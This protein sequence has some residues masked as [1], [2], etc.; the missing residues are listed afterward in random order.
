MNKIMK[1]CSMAILMLGIFI[2]A[3]CSSSSGI[4]GELSV[5]AKRNELVVT[6]DFEK[7]SKLENGTATV[8]VK[9]Y[10]EDESYNTSNTVTLENG[11]QGTTTFEKL[12][13]D[14]KYILKLFVSIS[15]HEEEIYKLETATKNDGQDEESAITI[16]TVEEFKNI[17]DDPTAYYKLGADLDF[18]DEGSIGLFSSSSTAFSGTFDGNGYSIKNATLTSNQ[19]TGLFG[20][21]SNA[22]IK[23]LTITDLT[24]ELKSNLGNSIVAIGGVAGYAENCIFENVKAENFTMKNT[25]TSNPFTSSSAKVYFGGFAGILKTS[26][27]KSSSI[28]N[29]SIDNSNITLSYI[30]GGSSTT[31]P[32]YVYVGLFAGQII[33]STIVESSSAKGNLDISLNL[34]TKVNAAIGGFTGALSSE[35]ILKS[36]YSDCTIKATKSGS[37]VN[38]TVA[39]G[40]LIGKNPNDGKCNVDDCLAIADITILGA[41]DEEKANTI[42]FAEKFYVGG[43]I[44]D[45]GYRSTEGVK[46]SVYSPKENGIK[47]LSQ[48]I[49]KE[50]DST[51]TYNAKIS[52]TFGNV[53]TAYDS[54]ILSKIENV[55]ALDDVKTIDI[56]AKLTTTVDGE[57]QT[58]DVEDTTSILNAIIDTTNVS[59][60]GIDYLSETLKSLL[61]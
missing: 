32:S 51:T 47:V 58:N 55:Y 19:Y 24:F 35:K 39:V 40:G 26:T 2:L 31:N 25:G 8:S 13:V 12:T 43:L 9:L 49:A 38:G 27:S 54:D 30:S 45:L 42:K 23:N 34:Y 60:S 4:K 18:K 17:K 29:C 21:A 57:E 41:S 50:S 48:I 5:V 20:Y 14:T 22:T 44:G 28:K 11:I 61:Q 46:N 7:N 3:A 1:F 53:N 59:S 36:C 52:L 33:G 15:G 56:T 6:A 37:N 16:T 10:N